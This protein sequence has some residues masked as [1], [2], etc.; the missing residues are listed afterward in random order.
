MESSSI[1]VKALKKELTKVKDSALLIGF[2][3]EKLSLNEEFKKLDMQFGGII[4]SCIK[5]NGF[6]AEKGEIKSVYTNKNIKNIVLV[7]LGGEK[8]YN[9]DVLSAIIADA[10]KRLRDNSTES[11]S[12]F[13]SSFGNG[14]FK[15]EELV[16][17]IALSSLIGLYRF[18]E[19]KTKD[20]DKIKSIKQ[21][22]IITS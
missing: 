11:F 4:S 14:K 7:G 1:S 21:I 20:R 6:K 18:T 10:S 9:F 12:I 3:K 22:T 2:F 16:E 15:D 19:Y 13:L 17:K 5:N 8:K